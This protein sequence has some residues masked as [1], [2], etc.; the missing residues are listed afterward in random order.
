MVEK[1]VQLDAS[2]RF[3][4]NTFAFPHASETSGHAWVRSRRTLANFI[5]MVVGMRWMQKWFCFSMHVVYDS[6]FFA[7]PIVMIWFKSLTKPPR[8][9]RALGM[10]KLEL[11]Y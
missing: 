2:S 1:K 8:D 11:C 6:M 4:G 3:G 10:R 7:S 9:T 5:D